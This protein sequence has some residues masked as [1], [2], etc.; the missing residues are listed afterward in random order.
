MKMDINVEPGYSSS[1]Y[2]SKILGYILIIIILITILYFLYINNKN[3][4]KLLKSYKNKK[5]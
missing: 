5:K 3:I 2:Y 1:Y 4:K